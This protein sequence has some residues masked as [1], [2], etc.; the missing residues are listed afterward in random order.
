MDS[1]VKCQRFLATIIKFSTGW[2]KPPF[3]LALT[4]LMDFGD[5]IIH[6]FDRE[7][8]LFYDLERIWRDGKTVDI[9]ELRA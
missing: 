9:D 8:R 3:Y 4:I 5:V 2:L 1:R 7:H 6:I